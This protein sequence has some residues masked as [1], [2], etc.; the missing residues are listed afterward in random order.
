MRLVRFETITNQVYAVLEYDAK[1]VET[2]SFRWFS[3]PLQIE[4]NYWR[5]SGTNRTRVAGPEDA[6][7]ISTNDVNLCFLPLIEGE[8]YYQLE[9]RNHRRLFIS[10]KHIGPHLGRQII[11]TPLIP[12]LEEYTRK[13]SN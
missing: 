2:Y 7:W 10:G 8:D 3:F 4:E 6:V 1:F 12:G 13:F 11:V 5:I 9:Y